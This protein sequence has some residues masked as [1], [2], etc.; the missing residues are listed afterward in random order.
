MRFFQNTLIASLMAT[1]LFFL[2]LSSVNAQTFTPESG[3]WWNPDESGSGYSIEIQ[4]NFL[5]V[6]FYVYDDFGNP[7]WYTANAFLEGDGGNSLFDTDLNY[8]YNGTCIDCSYTAPE[9]NHG[10]GGPV[11]ID[12]LTETT[13]TI[14]FGGAVKNIERFNFI[15]GDELGKM[16]GEWQVV[17]D[18]SGFGF[19]GYPFFADVLI[20]NNL[21]VIDGFDAVTGC[22][23][24]STY[25]N[26]CTNFAYLSDVAAY[27]EPSEG[28]LYAV[29]DHSDTHYMLYRL[30]TGLNQFDGDAYVYPKNSSADTDVTGYSVR[31]FRSASRTFVETGQGPSKN[32][33]TAK[34]SQN[35]SS[36]NL[37][38]SKLIEGNNFNKLKAKQYAII[39]KLEAQLEQR[40]SK[41]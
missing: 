39:K 17:V 15:L 37:P 31:G 41:K 40:K 24:E 1:T 19:D 9:T 26:D 5:F 13:A 11:T 34:T 6:A 27:F 12:F 18:S 21:E 20:F 8:T 25:Y 33:G 38:D 3:F 30:R 35:R 4:D 7:I 29:V 16:R 23:S 22:R 14:Q 36:P 2:G 10:E 32:T 28:V